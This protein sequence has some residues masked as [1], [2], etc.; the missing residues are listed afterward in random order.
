MRYILFLFLLFST[1]KAQYFNEFK[2][3]QITDFDFDCRN[4]E[5]FDI[6]SSFYNYNADILFEAHSDSSINIYLMKYDIETDSFYMPREVTSNMSQNVKP[7]GKLISN[8]GY[9]RFIMWETNIND[10]WDIAYSIQLNDGY[11]DTISTPKLLLSSNA[12]ERNPTFVLRRNQIYNWRYENSSIF[13]ILY[14]KDKSIFLYTSV[15]DT[16][17]IEPIFESSDSVLYYDASGINGAGFYNYGQYFVAIEKTDDKLPIVVYRYRPHPDSIL[18]SIAKVYDLGECSNPKFFDLGSGIENYR[19]SL[20]FENKMDQKKSIK[21]IYKSEDFGKNDKA[22]TLVEKY[23]F[24]SFNFS[25]YA[26][27]ICCNI[28]EI[29]NTYPHSYNLSR[30]DS[31]FIFVL[32]SDFYSDTLMSSKVK[33]AKSKIGNLGAM[34]SALSY[35]IWEDSSSNNRINLFG[36]GRYEIV[37]GIEEKEEFPTEFVLEQNYPNPF[38][39]STTIQYS[40]P[41]VQTHGYASV[42]LVVYDILGREVA[43]LVNSEQMPG[44][45]SVMFDASGLTSGLYFYK[46]SSGGFIST[47][48]MILIK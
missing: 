1:F 39:P 47:K 45:Y 23:N 2:I 41:T 27:L 15:D 22:I 20:A 28:R 44:S 9:H 3:R 16:T 31:T 48:K 11:T 25:S 24:E 36:K 38:N 30:N 18:S 8:Y 12:D 46:L 5:F 35:T 19:N 32:K 29:S 21:V 7:K 43:T 37:V 10:N 14:E 26:S 33:N 42:Q 40:I 17:K 6:S 4:P 34:R 13:E